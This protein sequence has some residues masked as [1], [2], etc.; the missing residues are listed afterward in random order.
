MNNEIQVINAFNDGGKKLFMFEWEGKFATIAPELMAFE[1]YGN[2]KQSWNDIKSRE[3]FEEEFEFLTLQGNDLKKFKERLKDAYDLTLVVRESLTTLYDQ[4][5]LVPRLDI[6]FE[7]GIYG[8]MQISGTEHAIKF[9]TFIRRDV[10]PAIRENGKFDAA[11]Y[12]I[13]Q[14][15]DE[16]EKQLRLKLYKAQEFYNLDQDDMVS[17]HQVTKA[18]AALDKYIVNKEVVQLKETVATIKEEMNEVQDVLS[19]TSIDRHQQGEITNARNRRVVSML[20]GKKTAKYALF[21]KG[22][23]EKCLK[24]LK[25]SLR[26]GSYK[27]IAK[28][29]YLD[30]LNY[31]ANWNPSTSLN[32]EIIAYWL[33]KRDNKDIKPDKLKALNEYLFLTSGFGEGV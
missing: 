3:D 5:K 10:A 22:Y 27:D 8:V 23:C 28:T 29:E 26:I 33:D 7:E 19:V 13:K 30:A 18:Q 4:Y 14:L 1:G 15:E 24:D 9:K 31:I 25:D 2:P 32:N 20:G 21:S 6:V 11:E 17:L 12:S 16:Q